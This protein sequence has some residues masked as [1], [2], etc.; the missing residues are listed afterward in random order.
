MAIRTERWKYVEYENGDR[1]L[2]DLAADPYEMTNVATSPSA[3]AV[4]PD[5]RRR[6]DLL[7][8]A[9]R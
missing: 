4:L 6:L 5:L 9:G 2:Y 1:E 3:A 7:R 8:R